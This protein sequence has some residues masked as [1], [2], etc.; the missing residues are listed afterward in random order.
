[1][2]PSCPRRTNRDNNTEG[3]REV[4]LALLMLLEQLH[5]S[6]VHFNE[7]QTRPG[8]D[9]YPF[10]SGCCHNLHQPQGRDAMLQPSLWPPASTSAGGTTSPRSISTRQHGCLT[11][12]PA[13]G[14]S[15][16]LPQVFPGEKGPPCSPPGAR[17]HVVE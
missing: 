14:T 12:M 7:S 15:I 6:F 2:L 13:P 1:M 5:F 4:T 9:T 17:R 8:D 10:C 16:S 3:E 11:T